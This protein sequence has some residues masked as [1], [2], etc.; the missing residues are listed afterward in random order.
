MQ[1]ISDN[2]ELDSDD[3]IISVKCGQDHTCFLTEKGYVLTCGWSADGQLGQGIF[4]VN[5]LPKKLDGDLKGNRIVQLA[6]K[7]DFVLALSDEGEVFGWGNNE[8]N[9]L[10]MTGS[11]EPQIGI[12]KH[13]NI[14]DYVTR[15]IFKIAASGTHCLIIDADRKVWVW[16][17][18]LLGKGPKHENIIEPS[19]IPD[20]LFGRYP[21]IEH[22]L[23]RKP[24]SVD[25]GLNN[26]SVTLDDGTLYTWGK[27][28]YGNLGT[29]DDKDVFFPLRVNI[30]AS[31]KKIEFG[32]DQTMAICKTIL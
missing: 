28:K 6:T 27:N 22:S 30:P 21:E 3:K 11:N 18:G 23:N 7:G 4:T 13:L 31:V 32:P 9:Q 19:L 1:N 12:P 8:Y 26:S 2:I 5:S 20:T 17:F 14:P 29:G 16:G 15:P 10:T 25:C 24:I